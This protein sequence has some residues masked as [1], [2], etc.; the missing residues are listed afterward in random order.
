MGGKYE[1]GILEKGSSICAGS[2]ACADGSECFR[3]WCGGKSGECV[4]NTSYVVNS[5][6]ESGDTTGW[7]ITMP[8]ADSSNVGY[9]V[10]TDS[11]MTN[12]TTNYFNYWN[13]NSEAVEFS[14]SQT[15]TSVPAGTYKVVF[16]QDG[17]ENAA[18]GFSIKVAGTEK[19]SGCNGK[20]ECVELSG[21]RSICTGRRIRCYG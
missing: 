13:N 14:M 12:N 17:A 7:T 9:K 18:S 11:G 21:I 2:N 6:F 10:T 3:N 16:R 5:D 1:K 4:G 20:L 19:K 8:D 15:I